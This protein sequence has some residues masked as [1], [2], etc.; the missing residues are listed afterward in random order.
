MKSR[1]SPLGLVVSHAGKRPISIELRV[2]YDYI[3][4]QFQWA[5]LLLYKP[6]N[7]C[8]YV[9]SVTPLGIITC[10]DRQPTINFTWDILLVLA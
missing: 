3:I 4:R 8:L 1:P 6:V 2:C 7:L 5:K 10:V 9:S